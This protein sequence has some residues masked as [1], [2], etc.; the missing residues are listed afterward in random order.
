[1]PGNGLMQG[2]GGLSGCD[3]V[4]ATGARPLP[5][6][7]QSP[8]GAYETQIGF[9]ETLRNVSNRL[10]VGYFLLCSPLSAQKPHSN[11]IPIPSPGMGAAAAGGQPTTQQSITLI[12]NLRDSNGSPLT[13]EGVVS[14]HSSTAG[15]YRVATARYSFGFRGV[16]KCIWH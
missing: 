3:E 6:V 4:W 13:I 12:V 2:T 16:R 8:T 1:M 14:L 15:A 7:T 10:T 11:P 5:T 9:G